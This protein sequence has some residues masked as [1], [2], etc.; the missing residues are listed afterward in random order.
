MAEKQVK[1][2]RKSR[3][4]SELLAREI[5]S[6]EENLALKIANIRENKNALEAQAREKIER[7][8]KKLEK[9]NARIKLDQDMKFSDQNSSQFAKKH[10]KIYSLLIPFL[11]IKRKISRKIEKYRS[12]RPHRSFKLTPRSQTKRGIEGIGGYLSFSGNV[13]RFISV[14]RWMYI[15]F[16]L[17]FLLFATLIIGFLSQDNFNALRESLNSSHEGAFYSF[18]ALF[19]GALT[20]TSGA[21]SYLGASAPI[22]MVLLFSYGWLALVFIVREI[23][24]GN[25]KGLKLRDGIYGGGSSVLSMICLMFTIAV[26]AIPFSIVMMIY[27]SLSSVGV[28]NGDVAIENMAAWCVLATTAVLTLYWMVPTFLAMVVV[29]L[30][31]V[32]PF[33]ALKIAGN[34]AVSRRLKI[35]YRLFAMAVP[36]ALMW[37]LILGAAIGFDTVLVAWKITWFPLVP[38]AVL[39]LI[40]LSVIWCATYIYLLVDKIISDQSPEVPQKL[41]KRNV[42]K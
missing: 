34:M 10:P 15:K 37:I 17:V 25:R 8:I 9:R 7:R 2:S 35:L 41:P 31:G 40:S 4:K 3:V 5:S 6:R 23:K 16:F 38:I 30:P 20:G 36:V 33:V 27:S 19:S 32:Y 1:K 21:G 24:N 39:L 28:I 26:Q 14:N 11:F 13:W 22:A 18:V 42:K 29:S 12:V